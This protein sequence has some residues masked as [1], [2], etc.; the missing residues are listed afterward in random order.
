M[1]QCVPLKSVPSHTGLRARSYTREL[2]PTQ[3][4]NPNS[5][6]NGSAVFAG[7]TVMTNRQ[8]GRLIVLLNHNHCMTIISGFTYSTCSSYY[9][10][11]TSYAH[12]F[13]DATALS[14]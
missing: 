2:E 1:F 11:I 3:V 9:I 13:K 14:L 7:L 5:I 4:C 8:S 6:L 10:T 12:A